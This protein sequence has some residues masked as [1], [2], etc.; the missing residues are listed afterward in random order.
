MYFAAGG[1]GDDSTDGEY[2]LTTEGE[3]LFL[4]AVIYMLGGSVDPALAGK[5]SP[6][7]N[8]TVQLAEA[9][10]LSWQAG[11]GAVRHDVYL[12]TSFEDVNN[13]DTSDMTGIYRGR[14]NIFIY[15]P[16]EAL[17]LGRTYYWRIDE[18][19]A[20]NTTVHKG[21]TWNLTVADYILVDDFE[22]YDAGTNEIWWSWHD[23]LGYVDADAV[24][25][26]G[27]GTGSEVGDGTTGS[28]TEETI[29]HGGGQSMPYLYDNNKPPD[30]ISG[31]TYWEYSEATM[32]LTGIRD[33]TAQGIKAL[34]LW[35]TGF[36]A[37]FGSFTES[38]AGTYTITA[39]GE[40][41]WGDSDQFH[42]AYKELNGAGT[43]IAKVQSVS[44]THGFAKAGVMI[45]DTLD[46]NSANSALLITPEN[47]VRFQW[48]NSAGDSSDRVFDDTVTAPQWVKLTRELGGRVRAAYSADGMTWTD[49]DPVTTVIMNLPMYIGLAVTSHDISAACVAEFS[50][51]TSD[52]TGQWANQNIGITS[53]EAEPMYVVLSNKN[54]TTGTV[55]Y[56]DN[57]NKDPNA[58]LISTWTQWN[59]DLKDFSDQGVDLTDVNSIGIG[60]GDRDNP[61]AGG[62]GKMLFDDMRLYQPRYVADKVTPLAAD[63]T[64]EGVV[65]F[66]DLEI[67]VSD[68]L[69][70]DYTILAESPQAAIA[71]WNLDNNANDS[72]GSN[73]GTPVGN[74]VY[75]AGQFSQAITLDGDDYV[76]LG[77]PS[78][79]DF[80]TV[81]WSISA[82]VKTRMTGTG[83]ENKGVIYAK[84]GDRTGGVR[85]GLYV[86]EDQ[87]VQG[88]IDLVTDDDANKR[89]AIS[90]ISVSDGE[91]HHI[92]GQRDGSTIRVYIDGVVDGVNSTLPDGYDLSG[93]S[94]HNAY[95][96]VVT[97][98]TDASLEKFLRGSVDDVRIYDYALSVSEILDVMGESELYVP[99]TSQANISDEEPINSKKVNFKDFAVLADDWLKEL[100]WPE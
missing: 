55:Y 53:N 4:N 48:R 7:S 56:D 70:G 79:L 81:D 3:K 91:W 82:W 97:D 96:G 100:L 88:S 78:L 67:M 24:F 40:D 35:F 99:L 20:D 29:V 5:P 46:P 49:M 45:R 33:W 68:W 73:H 22:D 2:N 87:A 30:L 38:P 64:G 93:T 21:S 76:D 10:L 9:S 28:F 41:I 61:Q 90:G 11:E 27:N 60:F 71:W 6:R 86:N 66:R 19:E 17:E 25:H 59:I 83:D 18:V 85:Y 63:F 37:D 94:Q 23:G 77:N 98:N 51:I 84:G 74:P 26:P 54:S 31:Q 57:E 12:G 47:G 65:D 72:A 14:Q 34:S 8:A 13:A 16:S 50:D 32:T 80:G 44:N 95:I 42:F 69:D 1:R 52:G 39:G 58:S 15:T 92:V 43:I 36:P 75:E 89:Q 62:A